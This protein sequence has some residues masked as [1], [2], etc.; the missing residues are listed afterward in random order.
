MRRFPLLA[1][2]LICS[3]LGLPSFAAAQARTGTVFLTAAGI[4]AIDQAPDG[5]SSALFAAPDRGGTTAGGALALGIHLTPRFSARLETQVSGAVKNSQVLAGGADTSLF[6]IPGVQVLRLEQTIATSREATPVFALLAF[7][8]DGARLS[9]QLAGGLG[10]VH[11]TERTS[12]RTRLV[13]GTLPA[14][15]N[16]DTLGSEARVSDYHAVAVVGADAALAFGSHAA[17]VPQVRA[18]VLA[19]GLSLRPGL[20]LRWTF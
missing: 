11:Q 18:Y 3:T 20:G 12:L 13:G 17:L 16:L 14:G 15:V 8:L 7:H 1:A 5:G 10:M 19:G 6:P 4:A 9:L 2:A